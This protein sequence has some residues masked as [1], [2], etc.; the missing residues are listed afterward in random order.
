MSGIESRLGEGSLHCAL[1]KTSM[2]VVSRPQDTIPS[3]QV[4]QAVW[5][6]LKQV[7]SDLNNTFWGAG[8]KKKSNVLS[9]K[10]LNFICR[11]RWPSLVSTKSNQIIQGEIKKP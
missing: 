9:L 11:N 3:K 5:A 1:L 2:P 7:A 6:E 10:I 4:H 8:G